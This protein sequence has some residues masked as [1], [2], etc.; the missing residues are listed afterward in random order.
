M[1][2]RVRSTDWCFTLND[3]AEE[4]A[5]AEHLFAICDPRY[6]VCQRERGVVGTLHY[7]GYVEFAER[8]TFT[9]VKRLLPRAHWEPRGGTRDQARDYARKETSRVDGPWEFGHW[10]SGPGART[11]LAS[12]HTALEQGADDASLWESHFAIMWRGSKA[13]NAYRLAK[14][15]PRPNAEPLA[16][17]YWGF[18]GT[19]KSRRVRELAGEDAYWVSNPGRGQPVWFDGYMGQRS[20]VFD[21][22]YGWI[23]WSMLLRLLDRNPLNLNCKGTTALC[24]ATTFYFTSNAHPSM[25]YEDFPYAAL[26]RRITIIECEHL[27]FEYRLV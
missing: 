7:Q 13:A 17:V 24:L 2:A 16:L 25:W 1:P 22:F 11:D 15:V 19:G 3:A 6:L 14:G 26:E 23:P 10:I 12:L 18:T 20:I 21:D 8:Q 27:M 5:D 4:E 9:G